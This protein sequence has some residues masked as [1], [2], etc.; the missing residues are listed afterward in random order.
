MS[1]SCSCS[2]LSGSSCL[3]I[4]IEPDIDASGLRISCAMP[5]GH[6]ADC[7]EALLDNRVA[8]ELLDLCHV[9]KR[10]QQPEST[11]RCLERASRSGR[12]RDRRGRR[13]RG[14]VPRDEA[15]RPRAVV[16]HRTDDVPGSC[17]T[18]AIGR[19]TAARNGRPVIAS[20]ARLKV[21]IAERIVRRGQ[22]AR[23]AVDDLLVER[24][25][26]G[27]LAWRPAR[28]ARPPTAGCRPATRSAPRRRKSRTRS[29]QR[30]NGQRTATAAPSRSRSASRTA[31]SPRRRGTARPPGQ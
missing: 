13:P 19:P 5:G 21:R 20:A 27:N 14:S 1:I 28:G 6:F 11:A 9:L 16:H 18:S 30:C 23:Q 12:C 29:A 8:L 17:R 31:A 24:L 26:V 4:W 3:R 10:E 15:R 22:P 7:G 25:Q 2:L